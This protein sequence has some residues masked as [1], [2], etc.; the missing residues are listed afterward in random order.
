[1][2]RSTDGGATWKRVLF[3]GDTIG[4]ADLAMD[5]R[6]S[7]VLYAAMWDHLRTPWEIRAP[8]V[9]AAAFTRASTAARPGQKPVLVCPNSLGKLSVSTTSD[10]RRVYAL[11]ATQVAGKSGLYR[12]GTMRARLGP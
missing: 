5:P 11:V 4:P 6:D 1:M 7:K 3:T 8:T 9:P 2:F 10:P 12:S